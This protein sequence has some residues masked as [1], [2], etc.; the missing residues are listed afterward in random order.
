MMVQMS[1]PSIWNFTLICELYKELMELLLYF[2]L[3]GEA[4]MMSQA[5]SPFAG[6]SSIFLV[7]LAILVSTFLNPFL[8]FGKPHVFIQDTAQKLV[9]S[10]YV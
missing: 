8:S 6:P 3:V 1:Q 2:H 10:L 9:S 4:S 7:T 5:N